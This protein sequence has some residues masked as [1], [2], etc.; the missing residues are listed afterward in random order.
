M[1]QVGLFPVRE[2][3]PYRFLPYLPNDKLLLILFRYERRGSARRGGWELQSD[4]WIDG[5]LIIM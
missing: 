3:D 4:Q 5:N 2:R 1:L